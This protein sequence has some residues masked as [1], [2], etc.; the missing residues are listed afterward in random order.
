MISC[1][2]PACESPENPDGVETCQNCGEAIIPLLRN[3]YRPTSLL[4]QGGFGRTYLALDEDRLNASCVIKQFSPQVQGT[5]AMEKAVELFKK[6][7]ERLY[8]L[9]EHPQIPT[10]LAYFEQDK[11]LYLVQ[12]FVEGENLF[13]ELRQQ[14]IRYRRAFGEQQIRDV[15]A[16]LL[17]ILKFI[18]EHHVIHRDITPANIIRRKKDNRLVLIDFGVAKQLSTVGTSQAGTRIGTEGYAPM[19]QLRS[20]RVYPASDL[21]SLGATC[22]HLLTNIRPENLYDPLRGCWT[23]RE[24]LKQRGASL[25]HELEQILDKLVQ[26]LVSQR[27]QSAD[28]VLQDLRLLPA[29]G[30]PPNPMSSTAHQR[31]VRPPSAAHP[32]ETSP[33]SAPPTS[34]GSSSG[35]ASRPKVSGKSV[36]SSSPSGL[37]R[38]ISSPATSKPR[39]SGPANPLGECI[40]TLRGHSSWITSIV[41]ST[42][43]HR[44]VSAS[45]DD[46]VKIWDITTGHLLCTLKGH[47]RAVN[48]VAI[49]P[50]SSLV[51]SGGDD[52]TVRLWNFQTGK[53]LSTLQEHT[54]DVNSVFVSRDGQLLASGSEDR[55]VKLWR[56]PRGELIRTLQGRAGMIKSVAISPNG[57]LVASGGLDN[58][59]KLWNVDSGEML[60][61]LIG[62]FNSVN[63]VTFGPSGQ[64][65]ASGGKDKTIKLWD[66]STGKMMRALVG[67]LDWVNSV[68]IAPSG[69]VLA[70]ASSDGTIRLWNL[71]KGEEMG[72]LSEHSQAVESVAISADGKLLASG[73][74]DNTIKIWHV[75]L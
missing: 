33:S 6:E 9:G 15:L 57:K 47:R 53:L 10:L 29:A 45:L 71:D 32:A 52:D 49:S 37:N 60:N 68:K 25:S 5:K 1:L 3:R 41:I 67:H 31:R 62:H 40:Y 38:P 48:A 61:T 26:D 56:L 20:G 28:A 58:K 12:Q 4:G 46:T 75:S 34:A 73:G 13:N 23:W 35:V 50:D 27:Y 54:R 11:R 70:S 16:S 42:D 55:T 18:H 74:K 17:P 7:A 59:I 72:A 8:E 64:L 36:Q 65:L 21:Y 19:E 22:L 43:G 69:K 30:S 24:Q 44:L 51:I 66:V 14:V 39:H 2:N 63:S